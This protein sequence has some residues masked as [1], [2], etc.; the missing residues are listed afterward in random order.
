[1]GGT[2]RGKE[3]GKRQT[4]VTHSI[5]ALAF[6][7]SFRLFSGDYEGSLLMRFL[8]V[9]FVLSEDKEVPLLLVVTEG[10]VGGLMIGTD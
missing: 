1:M 9:I 6:S 10:D 7:A 4:L 3:S 8:G 2:R 5:G